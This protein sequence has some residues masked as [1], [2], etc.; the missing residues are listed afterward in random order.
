[1]KQTSSKKATFL[2]GSML[3]VALLCSVLFLKSRSQ[4][5][6]RKTPLVTARANTPLQAH[7]SPSSRIIHPASYDE[8]R[9]IIDQANKEEKLL[10]VDFFA[11]WC[12]PCKM[13]GPVLEK[14]ATKFPSVTFVKIDIDEHQ[15]IAQHYN[16]K[17]I[18][19]LELILCGDSK[20][21]I[22]G[23]IA[24]DKLSKEIEQLQTKK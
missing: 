20:K 10:V 11:T 9:S 21:T 3:V 14:L 12:P 15:D 24:E 19:T 8:L 18:P 6:Q 22:H 5:D 4:D 13:L 2:G 7:K 23:F 16:I 17:S 1:M